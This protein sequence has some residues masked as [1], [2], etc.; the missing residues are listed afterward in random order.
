MIALATGLFALYL[1][2][3]IVPFCRGLISSP[4]VDLFNLLVP[5]AGALSRYSEHASY[6]APGQIAG[7]LAYYVV[8][9]LGF[10]FA[11][12]FISI[13]GDAAAQLVSLGWRQFID[14]ERSRRARTAI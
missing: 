4:V 5:S 1:A 11:A 3:L 13:L 6:D 7:L 12:L 8:G 9:S 10:I 14:E 2:W